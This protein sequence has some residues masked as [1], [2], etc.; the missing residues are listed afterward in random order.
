MGLEP[1]TLLS[2]DLETVKELYMY[3][4]VFYHDAKSTIVVGDCAQG[5]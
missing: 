1:I 2:D 4:H 5:T 3:E